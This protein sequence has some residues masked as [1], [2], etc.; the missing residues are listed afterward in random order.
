MERS[1]TIRIDEVLD[2]LRKAIALTNTCIRQ[3]IIRCATSPNFGQLIPPVNFF[4]GS[5]QERTSI[6]TPYWSPG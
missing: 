2:S 4:L 1:K 5:V 3:Q 6:L